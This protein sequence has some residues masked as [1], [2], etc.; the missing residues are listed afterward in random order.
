[1][2]DDGSQGTTAPGLNPLCP[3]PPYH[4][5]CCPGMPQVDVLLKAQT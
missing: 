4:P 5:T 3:L 1:M 2:N